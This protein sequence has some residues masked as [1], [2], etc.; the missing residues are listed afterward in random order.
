[1]TEKLLQYIWQFQ[2]FNRDGLVT[3][4]N[5]VIQVIHPGQLNHNQGPD[6]LD[7]RIKIGNTILAGSIELHLKTSDWQKHNHSSDINYKNVI[8]HVVYRNDEQQISTLPL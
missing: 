7:A 1:M 6:F 5:E 3:D 8:L 2:H 4:K